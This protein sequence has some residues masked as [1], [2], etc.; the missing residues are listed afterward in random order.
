MKLSRKS[1]NCFCRLVSIPARLP[2]AVA[3]LA[4][5]VGESLAK[6]Q[7]LKLEGRREIHP[8][9]G[10]GRRRHASWYR[11][12]T[13]G[14]AGGTRQAGRLS[15]YLSPLQTRQAGNRLHSSLDGS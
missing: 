4:G 10:I 6:L 8:L 11:A 15:H 2:F 1:T 9:A 5:D 14:D 13:G 3:L 12:A 7:A